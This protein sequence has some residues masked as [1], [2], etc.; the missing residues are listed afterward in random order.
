VPDDGEQGQQ[1]GPQGGRPPSV[2]ST[3]WSAF[4]L[5]FVLVFALFA[6]R[7]ELGPDASRAYASRTL[8]PEPEPELLARETPQNDEYWPCSD[9]HEGEPTN[10]TPRQLEDEHDDKQ[11]AHGDVWCL[12]CHAEED[13][14]ALHLADTAS[15]PFDESW[16]LCTQCHGAKL[17]DWR[18]GVHGKRT[19]HWWGPKQ[20]RTCVSCHDPHAPAFEPL[21]PRPPP[22]RPARIHVGEAVRP[23]D[24]GS[25][26]D[27]HEE[28]P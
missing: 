25:Q 11:L 24:T 10:R 21:T 3:T 23:E 18:A 16:R 15:V 19:G 2:R 20:Y 22:I 28:E 1:G 14:D 13:R 27:D 5:A 4:G 17:A 12:S 26:G 7:C 6:T 9:C 8:P